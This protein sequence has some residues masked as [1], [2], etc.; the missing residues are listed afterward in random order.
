MRDKRS[1]MI[2][3]ISVY[4]VSQDSPAQA[5]ETTSCKQQVRSIMLRGVK[6]PNPKKR[7]IEDLST[8]ITNWRLNEEDCDIILMA[9][10][11]EF[12]GENKHYMNF[13]NVLI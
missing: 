7:F 9:E 5:G 11:N 6:K 1:R 10:M 2:R 8:M 12:I 13:A 4:R 3:V